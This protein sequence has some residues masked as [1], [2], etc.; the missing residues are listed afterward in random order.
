MYHFNNFTSVATAVLHNIAI[1]MNEDIPQEWLDTIDDGQDN[2]EEITV[3]NNI[4]AR[5]FRQ[6]LINEHF[7][8][9]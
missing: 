1:E 9:L 6:M 8:R 4:A 5:H 3:P 7:A 2:N